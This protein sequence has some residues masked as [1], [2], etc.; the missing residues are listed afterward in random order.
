MADLERTGAA[1]VASSTTTTADIESLPALLGRLSDDVMTLVDTKIGL[2]KVEL[3][4]DA[5]VYGS[6]IGGMVAGGLVA[7]V[8]LALALVAV[9]FFVS[10]FFD[11]EDE[12][13]RYA[14][15]FIIT[16]VLFILI[17][18]AVIYFMKNRLAA[19]SPVPNRS[20]EELRKDKQWLKNET[21]G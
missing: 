21:Q 15:G 2:L 7:A 3:T 13:A 4:E 14:L 20:V 11:F 10:T 8:G 5:K 9:A 12:A 16:G 18:A 19:R 17:G 1:P 6:A